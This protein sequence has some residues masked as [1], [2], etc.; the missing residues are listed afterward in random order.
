MAELG[1]A[2]ISVIPSMKGGA[3]QLSRELTGATTAAAGK[4]GAGFASGFGKAAIKTMGAI[5][6]GASAGAIFSK[7]WNRMTAIDNAKAKLSA[8]GNST[9]AVEQISVNANKAVKGTA[10]GMDAAMTAAASATAAGIKPGKELTRY[11]TLMGDAASVAGVDMNE[12]GSIFNKVAANGKVTTE[13]MNQLADRGIPIWQLL[14]KETGKSMDE[15]RDSIS[16]GEVDIAAFQNAIETGMG[17]AA[18]KIGST[19]ITGAISNINASFSRMGAN[20]L[21]SADD[22]DS[23]AGKLL[24]LFNNLMGFMSKI[25]TG[26]SV[27]GQ[28]I[29]SILGP[30]MTGL[31][32]VF[33]Q[34]GQGTGQLSPLKN[35]LLSL[36]QN[37]GAIVGVLVPVLVPAL[38][39][40]FSAAG[41]VAKALGAVFKVV[42]KA[43]PV[44]KKFASVISGVVTRILHL[45]T[46]AVRT[47]TRHLSFSGLVAKVGATFNR[48]KERIKAPL[49]KA[50]EIVR[51]AIQKIKNMF[52]FN[53]GKIFSGKI[54]LPKVS[55]KKTKDGGAS[56][57]SSTSTRRFAKA[58]DTPYMFNRDTVFA[59]GEAGDE[60]LYG[61]ASLM[62]D[63][64]EALRAAVVPF[65][66][67]KAPSSGG[68]VQLVVNLDSK[69]IGQATV[70]YLNG[71]TIMF[72]TNPVLV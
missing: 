71:Q 11:L 9:K 4:S 5:G 3:G 50:R 46:R 63:I 55:V 51:K 56:T 67:S 7:G 53:V 49:D 69:T 47:V 58:M 36:G 70:D 64:T 35:I 22:A 29:G 21:G 18:K 8:L 66:N 48:V 41:A 6:V 1:K 57:S 32:Q 15:L 23:F 59:A 40:V 37:I 44:V 14:A 34:I 52:P 30:I 10:Y 54:S 27:V 17:G 68:T 31:G 12:M 60:I 28:V 38:R 19:T 61:K 43:F 42:S 24:G 65:D 45:V 13:E 20:L 39:L 16:S 72:G 62:N 25:E 33:T 26:A 2:Y